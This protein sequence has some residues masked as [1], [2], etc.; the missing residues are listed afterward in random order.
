MLKI[1]ITPGK[2]YAIGVLTSINLIA[3]FLL[4]ATYIDGIEKNYN[5]IFCDRVKNKISN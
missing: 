5:Q 4:M 1:I 2:A 3:L